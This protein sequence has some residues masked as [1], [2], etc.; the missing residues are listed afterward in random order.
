MDRDIAIGFARLGRLLVPHVRNPLEEEQRQ[1]VA[2]PIGAIDGGAAQG[3]GGI[4]QRRLQ[5]FAVNA[6]PSW[7]LQFAIL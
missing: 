3:V 2:L 7:R 6:I 4:P 1:D 5:F